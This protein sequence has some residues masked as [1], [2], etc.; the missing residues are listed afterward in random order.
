[1]L[2]SG[3]AAADEPAMV[4]AW[5]RAGLACNANLEPGVPATL[6]VLA[7]P[8]GQAADG[9]IGAEFAI[10][11]FPAEWLPSASVVANPDAA[12][13]LGDPLANGCNIAFPVCPDASS[14]PVLLL[15]IQ[16]V[17][18][19]PVEPRVLSLVAHRTT[20]SAPCPAVIPCDDMCCFCIFCTTNRPASI[21]DPTFCTVGV[22]R[23]TWSQVRGFYR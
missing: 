11:G 12:I 15:T 4:L 2:V 7:I 3:A 5:D 18:V 22:E 17:P 9:V 10:A 23:A 8:G 21:N 6:F 19:D 14:G 16:F 1:M 20:P 13:L